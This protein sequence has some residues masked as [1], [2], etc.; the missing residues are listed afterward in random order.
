MDCNENEE[1]EMVLG[2]KCEMFVQ[3]YTMEAKYDQN[4]LNLRCFVEE[5]G[6]L[7]A[8]LRELFF[9]VPPEAGGRKVKF[10]SALGL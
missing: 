1:V 6:R 7:V 5:T 4:W 2:F 10:G 9:H 3:K 8:V